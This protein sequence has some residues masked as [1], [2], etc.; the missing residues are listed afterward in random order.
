M[1]FNADE[2]PR[3]ALNGRADP[4]GF[5]TPASGEAAQYG[6]CEHGSSG[7]ETRSSVPL[8]RGYHALM[9]GHSPEYLRYP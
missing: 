2:L 8:M 4:R 9:P 5:G 6:C 3:H 1:R 7:Y